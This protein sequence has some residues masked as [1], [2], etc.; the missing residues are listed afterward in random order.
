MRSKGAPEPD[1][2]DSEVGALRRRSCFEVIQGGRKA[3][4]LCGQQVRG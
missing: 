2:H 4:T 1:E 3:G